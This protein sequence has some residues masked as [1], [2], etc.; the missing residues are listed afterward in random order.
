VD[1]ALLNNFVSE[2]L[3]WRNDAE[4]ALGGAAAAFV[5]WAVER[6]TDKESAFA[7]KLNQLLAGY[8]RRGRGSDNETPKVAISKEASSSFASWITFSGGGRDEVFCTSAQTRFKRRG[9]GKSCII[10]AINLRLCQAFMNIGR[11]C[12]DLFTVASDCDLPLANNFLSSKVWTKWEAKVGPVI[13]Q[14]TKE[15]CES[16]MQA[17]IT[18]S[19]EAGHPMLVTR[20][21]DQ[22]EFQGITVGVDG[23]WHKRG[24]HA[25]SNGGIVCAVGMMSRNATTAISGGAQRQGIRTWHFL[26][27]F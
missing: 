7:K 2:H 11:G 10:P 27:N 15:S 17:E 19:K 9:K 23:G 4:T 26:W 18:A 20:P 13:E 21:I 5:D 3:T 6:E 12:R 8:G 24:K 25:N 14:V 22:K 1:I 16:A